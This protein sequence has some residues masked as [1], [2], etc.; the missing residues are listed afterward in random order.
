MTTSTPN[1]A[2][3]LEALRISGCNPR[4]AGA[5]AW[6]AECP[7]CKLAGRRSFIEIREPGVI[8]CVT[9]HGSP[10]PAAHRRRA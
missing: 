8:C 9:A 10:P 3:L 4:E 6:I 2:N 7:T 1:I 5:G